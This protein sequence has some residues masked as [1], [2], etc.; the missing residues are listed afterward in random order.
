VRRFLTFSDEPEDVSGVLYECYIAL[1]PL[2]RPLLVQSLSFAFFP[3][4]AMKQSGDLVES[5][6]E[7]RTIPRLPDAE[8][9]SSRSSRVNFSVAWRAFLT[10]GPPPDPNPVGHIR[11]QARPP[12]FSPSAER[13]L[14]FCCLGA[15]C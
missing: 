5:S 12:L 11:S 4:E 2:R 3:D 7:A 9:D 10:S 8:Y 15:S 6:I 13:Q 14:F 1:F